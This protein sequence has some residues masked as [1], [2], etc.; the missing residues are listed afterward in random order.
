MQRGRG[1]YLGPRERIPAETL[2]LVRR[3]HF[4]N[5]VEIYPLEYRFRERLY[6][7]NIL[8]YIILI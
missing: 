6:Y 7:I 3:I 1:L 2:L 8:Y 5:S 4:D